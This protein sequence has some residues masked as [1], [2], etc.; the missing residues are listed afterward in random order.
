MYTVDR[1]CGRVKFG[2]WCRL[3]AGLLGFFFSHVVE[4]KVWMRCDFV[5]LDGQSA[6]LSQTFYNQSKV[7]HLWNKTTLITKQLLL[8]CVFIIYIQSIMICDFRKRSG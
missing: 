5:A 7:R 1:R 3:A 6:S 8:Q 2:I 4:V